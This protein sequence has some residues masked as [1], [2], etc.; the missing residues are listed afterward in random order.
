MHTYMAPAYQCQ[1]V[2]AWHSKAGSAAPTAARR[3]ASSRTSG[4]ARP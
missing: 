3:H 2:K 1:A 4:R